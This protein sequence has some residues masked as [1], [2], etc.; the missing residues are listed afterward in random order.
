MQAY[1]LYF[2][3]NNLIS[4]KINRKDLVKICIYSNFNFD[5]Y[6]IYNTNLKYSFESDCNLRK[7]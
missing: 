6:N 4:G 1:K 7:L 2:V 5:T 3:S